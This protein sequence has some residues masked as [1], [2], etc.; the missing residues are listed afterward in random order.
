MFAL[1]LNSTHVKFHLELHKEICN[2]RI[3]G[4]QT[5]NQAASIPATG[6]I[7]STD[8]INVYHS[9]VTLIPS[10]VKQN[11]AN[12][13]CVNQQTRPTGFHVPDFSLDFSS[14]SLG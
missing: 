5:P 3:T 9:A 11:Q 1:N 8:T 4:S 12:L 6:Q 10:I 13:Y 14:S 2:W 7:Q